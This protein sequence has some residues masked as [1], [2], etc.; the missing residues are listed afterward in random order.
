LERDEHPLVRVERHGVGAL[1]P[2][3]TPAVLLGEREAAA[4]CRVN[5]KPQ[6]ELARDVCQLVERVNYS[7]RGRARRARDANGRVAF[8]DVA[9]NRRAQEVCANVK[10]FVCVN[11]SEV[12][13]TDAEYVN[14]LDERVVALF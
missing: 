9:L 8:R 4:V 6:T 1:Q 13:A 12:L 11:L 7:G 14:A 5:V 3:Q 10:A 2:S